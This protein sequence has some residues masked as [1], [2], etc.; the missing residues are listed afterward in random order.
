LEV[1]TKVWIED[2]NGNSI[3]GDGRMQ[4]LEA[5]DRLG[6]L[7]KAA[8]EMNMSYRS[9]WG[10]IK[11]AEERLGLHLVESKLGG[12]GVGGSRLTPQGRELLDRFNKLSQEIHELALSHFNELFNR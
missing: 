10:K 4:I 7:N 2:E 12:G 3:F 5:V 9:A 11:T 1:R 6:S 8:Q